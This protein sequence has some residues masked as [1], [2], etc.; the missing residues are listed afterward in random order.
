MWISVRTT[1]VVLAVDLTYPLK[2]GQ[3]RVVLRQ[4]FT[5]LRCLRWHRY[6]EAGFNHCVKTA[7]HVDDV[8]HALGTKH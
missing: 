6:R 1:R 4:N 3:L 2:E 5:R 8:L 7:F